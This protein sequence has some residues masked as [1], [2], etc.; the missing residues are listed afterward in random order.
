MISHSMDEIAE[1]VRRVTAL[2]N[3]S[4]V[5]DGTP[6]EVFSRAESLKKLGLSVPQ[7]TKIA[8]YLHEMGLPIDTSVYTMSQAAEAIASLKGGGSGA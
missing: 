5:M 2:K 3:G 6:K 4:I 8:I 7:V 1:S